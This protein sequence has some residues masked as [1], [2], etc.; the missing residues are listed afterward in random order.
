MHNNP[1][2]LHSFIFKTTKRTIASTAVAEEF[3]KWLDARFR[4]QRMENIL[5]PKP[6]TVKPK[7]LNPQTLN[8]KSPKPLNVGAFPG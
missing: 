7:T 2:A 5:V 8:P 3:P 4:A 1:Q 6:E